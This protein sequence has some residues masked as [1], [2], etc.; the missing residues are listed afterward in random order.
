LSAEYLHIVTPECF[1]PPPLCPHL[2]SVSCLSAY[3]HTTRRG[4]RYIIIRVT[5]KKRRRSFALAN[6]LD[7]AVSR[8]DRCH[9]QDPPKQ[10]HQH[11]AEKSQLEWSGQKQIS[12]R[13]HLDHLLSQESKI[14]KIQPVKVLPEKVRESSGEFESSRES[15]R[16]PRKHIHISTFKDTECQTDRHRQEGKQETSK[17]TSTHTHTH[18]HTYSK[19]TKNRQTNTNKG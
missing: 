13:G 19:H 17:Q 1:P 11:Q 3:V 18:T 2:V 9:S 10:Q 7:H 15:A 14:L 5:Q 8:G 16:D 4:R 6:E 12:G